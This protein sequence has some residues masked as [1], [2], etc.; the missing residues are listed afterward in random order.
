MVRGDAGYPGR[1]ATASLGL[2]TS[3]SRPLIETAQ[4]ARD[5]SEFEASLAKLT[6]L[7]SRN[8]S[9]R[10]EALQMLH[11]SSKPDKERR[12]DSWDNAE[13]RRFAAREQQLLQEM[14]VTVQQMTKPPPVIPPW[15]RDPSSRPMTAG[16]MAAMEAAMFTGKGQA[17]GQYG[18]TYYDVRINNRGESLEYAKSIPIFGAAPD[19]PRDY[20]KFYDGKEFESGKRGGWGPGGYDVR[21]TS[22]G[23]PRDRAK[24]TPLFGPPNQKVVDRRKFYDGKEFQ[25]NKRGGYGP[26]GYDVRV[27]RRG[28]P[29]MVDRVRSTPIF[30]PK[31]GWQGGRP[32]SAPSPQRPPRSTANARKSPN[33][34]TP[35]INLKKL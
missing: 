13:L 25:D 28:S 20:N 10:N 22:T 16:Q 3:A 15:E 24:S 2:T 30:G 5:R 12:M 27:T 8:P 9:L 1:P 6:S 4:Q 32:G 17:T 21:V 26:G 23:T 31:G 11:A 7:A 19:K 33:A 34:R 18:G 14:G 29:R 35:P